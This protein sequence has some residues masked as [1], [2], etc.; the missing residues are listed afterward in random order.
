MKEKGANHYMV[1]TNLF[2][3]RYLRAPMSR[4]TTKRGKK[5]TGKKGEKTVVVVGALDVK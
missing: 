3:H 5:K 1:H 4:K 2:S